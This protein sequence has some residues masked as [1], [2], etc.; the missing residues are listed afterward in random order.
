MPRFEYTANIASYDENVVTVVKASTVAQ[1]A[2]KLQISNKTIYKLLSNEPNNGVIS[3]RI[4]VTRCSVSDI[5]AEN[6]QHFRRQLT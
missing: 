3:R 2:S 4:S 5:V 1:L 6:A